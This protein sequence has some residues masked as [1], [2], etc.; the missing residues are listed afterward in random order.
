MAS[1][2]KKPTVPGETKSRRGRAVMQK[3]KVWRPPTQPILICPFT[4][5]DLVVEAQPIGPAGEDMYRVRGKFWV[6][7]WYN[8]KEALLYDI[9]QREGLAPA[10]PRNRVPVLQ[11]VR[12]IEEPP[13]D[14]T[15]GLGVLSDRGAEI[16][17]AM[18]NDPKTMIGSGG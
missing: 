15:T 10:F 1:S 18:I 13:S 7:V 12:E 6:T 17:E 14:P 9:S 4:D 8:D 3:V 11:S 2:R 16:V 5:A